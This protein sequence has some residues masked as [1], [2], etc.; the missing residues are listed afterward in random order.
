MEADL[1]KDEI[2]VEEQSSLQNG[3][4]S[5]LNYSVYEIAKKHKLFWSELAELMQRCF[6]ASDPERKDSSYVNG[7]FM[8]VSKIVDWVSDVIR[9]MVEKKVRGGPRM[10]A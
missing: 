2:V 10:K 8:S 6:L 9:C 4:R 5:A 1:Q 3:A 7:S